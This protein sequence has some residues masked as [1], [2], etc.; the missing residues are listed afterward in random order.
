M[1]STEGIPLEIEDVKVDP[2]KGK[3]K[4][5]KPHFSNW[6]LVVNSN[7]VPRGT[8]DANRIAQIMKD[9]IADTFRNHILEVFYVRP[10]ATEEL[11]RETIEKIKIQQAAEVGHDPRGG[12]VHVHALIK[13]VHFTLL[14]IN[15]KNLRSLICGYMSQHGIS[16]NCYIDLKWVP[17]EKPLELYLRK[18]PI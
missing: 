14:Q 12:R 7:K 10:P 5:R 16:D 9:A 17:S 11:N 8:D 3:E 15:R 18:D 1:T 13:V 4:A 6:H 2:T